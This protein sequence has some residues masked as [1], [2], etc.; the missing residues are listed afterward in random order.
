MIK[1]KEIQKIVNSYDK[2]NITIG[3]LGGHSGS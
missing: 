2:K 1:I 3:V